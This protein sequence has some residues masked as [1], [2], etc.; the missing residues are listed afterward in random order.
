MCDRVMGYNFNLLTLII[1]RLYL[2]IIFKDTVE[3]QYY[4]Y[5]HL[6][7]NFITLKNVHVLEKSDKF[8]L[9]KT[10]LLHYQY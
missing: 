10:T 4:S 2:F 6:T 7:G 9:T 5:Y 1:M 8:T 3:Q